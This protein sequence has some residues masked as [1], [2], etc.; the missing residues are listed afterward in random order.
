MDTNKQAAE[1]VAAELSEAEKVTATAKKS[2]IKI[3][4]KTTDQ[5]KLILEHAFYYECVSAVDGKSYSGDF[6][7][8]KMGLTAVGRVGVAKARLNG[9]G[10]IVEPHIDLMH[11][12]MAQCQISV[13]EAPEWF[14]F[15]KMVDMEILGSV[16]QE[17]VKYE[18][19]FRRMA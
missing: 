8:K 7:I 6:R 13:V 18:N 12:W 9:G 5:Q 4:D 14:N 19:S 10:L 16:H 3:I 11:Q 1:Q 15:D 17:V 2:N